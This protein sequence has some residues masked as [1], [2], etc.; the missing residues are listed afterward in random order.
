MCLMLRGIIL[1]CLYSTQG[2]E[3]EQSVRDELMSLAARY[4]GIGITLGLSSGELEIIR[5]DCVGD[6][7]RALGQVIRTWLRQSYNVGVFGPPSWRSLV[8]TVDSPA[9]GG[10]HVIAKRIASKHKGIV[11]DWFLEAMIFY[12]L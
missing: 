7:R 10:N 12:L 1:I 9:G 11:E 8:K 3:D 4:D 6:S 2:P 5:R